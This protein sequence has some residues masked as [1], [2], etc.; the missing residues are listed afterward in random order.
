MRVKIGSTTY[1]SKAIPINIVLDNDEKISLYNI[2]LFNLANKAQPSSIAF[3]LA[4][5]DIPHEILVEWVDQMF[6]ELKLEKMK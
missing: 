5:D 4:P 6:K 1:D 2:I 3:T